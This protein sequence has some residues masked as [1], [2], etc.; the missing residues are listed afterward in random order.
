MATMR[1]AEMEASLDAMPQFTPIDTVNA[2]FAS[3]YAVGGLVD[4][5]SDGLP[6]TFTVGQEDIAVDLVLRTVPRTSLE[7]YVT[8]KLTYEGDGP[9]PPGSL[10]LYR[11]GAYLR[12]DYLDTLV[13]GEEIELGFG[14]DQQIVVTWV[15]E[16]GKE[17]ETGLVGRSTSIDENH[18]FTALNRH[19][20]PFT[21]E[22]VDRRPISQD[23]DIQVRVSPEA[24]P[25][26]EE[27][28]EDAPGVVLWRKEL[29]PDETLS[30]RNAF[31]I[32]Y[33]TNKIL[34]GR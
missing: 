5:L 13:P 12:E 20:T 34:L 15:D 22:I 9:L 4:V 1:A 18:L 19:G 14:I 27:G 3:T 25:P 21:V 24:T 26:D 33:P 11:D 7:A 31:T 30:V 23:D 28:F 16:G 10:R 6:R 17:S 8:A 2:A 29:Q 32:V